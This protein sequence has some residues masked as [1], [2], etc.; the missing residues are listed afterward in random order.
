MIAHTYNANTWTTEANGLKTQEQLVRQ[1]QFK[2][3]L[4]YIAKLCVK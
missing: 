4:S 2:A 1:T 3:S